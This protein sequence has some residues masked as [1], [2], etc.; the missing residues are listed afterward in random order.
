M[1]VILLWALQ[2]AL[3]LPCPYILSLILFCFLFTIAA[4]GPRG[5]LFNWAL[6]VFCGLS[7][8]QKVLFLLNALAVMRVHC[9]PL[10]SWWHSFGSPLHF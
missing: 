9:H 10:R 1:V 3:I 7:Y 6:D 2:S 5:L 8:Q 4:M